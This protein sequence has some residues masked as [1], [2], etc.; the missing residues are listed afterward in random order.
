MERENIISS[1]PADACEGK[2]SLH[3][4]GIML[5]QNIIEGKFAPYR[6]GDRKNIWNWS[7]STYTTPNAGMLPE[8]MAAE[9][10]INK[11]IGR[12]N[13]YT[14][15]RC[16]NSSRTYRRWLIR[17]MFRRLRQNLTENFRL[18]SLRT[19]FN[20]NPIQSN[21]A[22]I[23]GMGK[24]NKIITHS[25]LLHG[26]IWHDCQTNV[27]MGIF[28]F[29]HIKILVGSMKFSHLPFFIVLFPFSI[30]KF[31]VQLFTVHSEKW[32]SNDRN[33]QMS[34]LSTNHANHTIS[35]KISS[36]R[37]HEYDW[38]LEILHSS[39]ANLSRTR[40]ADST[41]F[42][43]QWCNWKLVFYTQDWNYPLPRHGFN[44]ST[45]CKWSIFIQ[46]LRTWNDDVL[47]IVSIIKRFISY[48]VWQGL[49]VRRMNKCMHSHWIHF[50]PLCS[51]RS[52]TACVWMM[53]CA[54]YIII[55]RTNYCYAFSHNRIVCDTFI[56][57]NQTT[58]GN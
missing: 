41:K 1:Q 46:S 42:S 38:R 39:P 16:T 35:S 17:F 36:F 8:S 47:H 3:C 26:W 9:K 7:L 31:T 33:I 28:H 55:E 15:E 56:K 11:K 24:I 51:L 18:C 40:R 58:A 6:R 14:S 50:H 30:I 37:S 49:W 25:T 21:S 32:L 57:M 43:V 34:N 20:A 22:P 44:S 45:M 53:Q 48:P 52:P 13:T 5:R 19:T 23:K 54:C 12:E 27:W 2:I 10:K 4:F 29:H